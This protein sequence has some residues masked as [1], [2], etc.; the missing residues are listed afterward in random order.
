MLYYII[1]TTNNKK[2]ATPRQAFCAAVRRWNYHT[3]LLHALD[4]AHSPFKNMQGLVAIKKIG[5]LS[6]KLVK[7]RWEERKYLSM[8]FDQEVLVKRPFDQKRFEQKAFWPLKAF[9]QH[10]VWFWWI[11]R[12]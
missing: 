11:E 7:K 10:H 12:Y 1:F 2:C 6:M 5:F 3:N 8:P 4:P 9:C